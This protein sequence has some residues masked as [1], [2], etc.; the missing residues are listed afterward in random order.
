M[1]IVYKNATIE[2]V[3]KQQENSSTLLQ[4]QNAMSHKPETIGRITG[5]KYKVDVPSWGNFLG[6]STGMMGRPLW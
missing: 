3:E 6:W 2:D 1:I 5:S 4:L